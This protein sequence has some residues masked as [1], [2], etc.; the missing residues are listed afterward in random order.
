MYSYHIGVSKS[1]RGLNLCHSLQWLY[2]SFISGWCVRVFDSL[3]Y[4]EGVIQ[5]VFHRP[6]TDLWPPLSPCHRLPWSPSPLV[7]TQ[8]VTNFELIM[9]R[10]LMQIVDLIFFWMCMFSTQTL[11]STWKA[12]WESKW[13]VVITT[14]KVIL[15]AIVETTISWSG[16]ITL[17]LDTLLPLVTILLDPPPS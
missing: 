15:I 8:I 2:K 5:K 17:R 6:S 10:P 1:F 12:L 13:S 9:S 7:T 4:G 16:D 3:R 14:F 11:I